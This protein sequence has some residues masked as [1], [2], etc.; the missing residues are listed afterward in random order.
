MKF[1]IID[2]KKNVNINTLYLKLNWE[3]IRYSLY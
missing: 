2:K 3:N 1:L